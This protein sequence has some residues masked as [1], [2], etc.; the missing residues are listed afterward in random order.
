MTEF[1][2]AVVPGEGFDASSLVRALV[3]AFGSARPSTI[4]TVE[5]VPR[6]PMGK[7]LRSELARL[8][9]ESRRRR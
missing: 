5:Q 9:A 7:P 2:L 8:Y 4:V 3:T 6:N 1:V